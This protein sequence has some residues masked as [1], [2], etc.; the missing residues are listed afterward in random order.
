MRV[1]SR[2]SAETEARQSRTMGSMR[3][4]EG[5]RRTP[6]RPRTSTVKPRSFSRLF[7]MWVSPDWV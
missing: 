7:I 1:I 4:P 6:L 5:I 3:C 2:S